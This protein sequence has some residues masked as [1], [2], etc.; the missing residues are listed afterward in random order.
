MTSIRRDLISL[1]LV[2]T[3]TVAGVL[4]ATPTV[5]FTLMLSDQECVAV[6]PLDG[7]LYGAL[8]TGGVA[9]WSE[10]DPTELTRWTTFDGLSSNRINDLY[11][12]GEHL[13]VAT[14][15]GGLTRVTLG[16]GGPQFRQ[17]T[18]LGELSS[19][20]VAVVVGR[21]VDGSERVFYG[22][23]DGGVGI[24]N[25]GLAG[26]IFSAD[27][28]AGLVN[29]QIRA[30]VF[31]GDDLWIGTADGVSVYSEGI[32]LDRSAG[33]ATRSVRDLLVGAGGLFVATDGGVYL[34]SETTT[35]WELLGASTTPMA[36]LTEFDG[37]LW[38]LTL[39]TT[40]MSR[41]RRW[42][43]TAWESEDIPE[44]RASTLA[45]SDRL[46]IA[47]QIRPVDDNVEANQ[48]F[49]AVRD[50]VDDWH[51]WTW[52]DL[53]FNEVD[54][55]EITPDGTVWL[56]SR[57]AAGWSGW[58][59][60]AWTQFPELASTDNDSLGLINFGSNL[61]NLES[62]SDGT[63]WITQFN[64]GGIIR[65]RPWLA[66]VDILVPGQSPL[67]NNRIVRMLA[68]SG[69]AMLFMSD[70]AG[71][72][73]LLDPD[74]WADP[75]SWRTLP[76]DASGLNGLIV[77]D[78][79]QAQDDLVWFTSDDGGLVLW[80]T[81]GFADSSADPTLGDFTDDIWTPTIISQ[82]PE[83]YDFRSTKGLAVDQSGNLWAGGGGGVVRLSLTSYDDA[84]IHVQILNH[85]REKTAPTSPGLLR[86][87]VNDIEIDAN[88]DAWV[89]HE[90][91]LD[92]IRVNGEIVEIDG[93][94]NAN[95]YES[96]G[97]DSVVGASTIRGIVEG[98][99]RELDRSLDGRTLVAGGGYGAILIEVGGGQGDAGNSLDGLTVY[100]NP[101]RPNEQSGGL[102]IGGFDS[103]VTQTS[104]HTNGGAWVEIYDIEGKLVHRNRN[105][106]QD[107]AFWDGLNFDDV[108]VAAGVYLL[109]AQLEGHVIVKPLAVV[110]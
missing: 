7:M 90:A 34:W 8:S 4:A 106:E 42:T 57:V 83:T 37:D 56:G 51:T 88:G 40:T 21:A 30:L 28:F 64:R 82:P 9:V 76:T 100:P 63:L 75:D 38:A 35:A 101:F 13:W 15:G 48:A 43:G 12:S 80:D 62:S 95:A 20:N 79:V 54:G 16:V 69:G 14:N 59:G 5:E 81:N 25:D 104:L 44:A 65:Y 2:S 60:E 1:W 91:G 32:F 49:L 66:D 107:V 11:W 27:N 17:Y 47:G 84:A 33:L 87:S 99:V 109:R 24:I 67:S 103:E 39:S 93:F 61:L 53:L 89:C 10:D 74:S 72:D 58:D 102:M 23:A 97:L 52:D 31:E 3:V 96:F 92:R 108:P 70:N 41:L 98:P 110:R 55:V 6:Q 45:A 85:W 94:T 19:L 46:W 105:V 36:S 22:L 86:G 18:G 77:R 26:N 50:G 68:L 29:D 71:V 78:A 73:L